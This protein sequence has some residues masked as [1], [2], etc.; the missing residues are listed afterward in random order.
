MRTTETEAMDGAT[1]FE[2]STGSSVVTV[3]NIDC[4]S[5]TNYDDQISQRVI[6]PDGVGLIKDI[7]HGHDQ[8]A[9]SLNSFPPYHICTQNFEAQSDYSVDAE[10][11]TN[12]SNKTKT[13]NSI[14]FG[15]NNNHNNN[16]EIY[17]MRI[18]ICRHTFWIS[19]IFI[20]WYT[21][22]GR[23]FL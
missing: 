18:T 15:N 21:N 1:A 6:E 19:I 4:E 11:G 8:R 20:H 12:T 22:P 2:E 9:P 3:V 10:S 7:D 14:Y 5:K 23:W 17:I 13:N 16:N